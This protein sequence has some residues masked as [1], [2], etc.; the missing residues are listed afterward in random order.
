MCEYG[1]PLPEGWVCSGYAYDSLNGCDCAC[2]IPDPDCDIQPD[3]VFG[4]PCEEMTC[5]LGYCSG[6]CDG[7]MLYVTES[8]EE[9]P[10]TADHV[11]IEERFRI[12]HPAEKMPESEVAENNDELP[13]FGRNHVERSVSESTLKRYIHTSTPS[14]HVKNMLVQWGVFDPKQTD[15]MTIATRKE[16]L[17]RA[18]R[19]TPPDEWTCNAAFYDAQDGCDVSAPSRGLY[20][21][22]DVRLC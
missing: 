11:P 19:S 4:C 15:V 10:V 21:L 1:A 9:V 20:I 3:I 16:V 12:D 7:F 6:F 2:G 5:T 17:N 13:L 8:A 14:E 18:S 22:F